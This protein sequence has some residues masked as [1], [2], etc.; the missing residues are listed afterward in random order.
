MEL[1]LNSWRLPWRAGG[2]FD[3]YE[4]L[5]A[6]YVD[7]KTNSR[8]YHYQLN[9]EKKG[10]EDQKMVPTKYA[11]LA[12]GSFWAT[13]NLQPTDAES[14]LPSP[15]LPRSRHTFP[16]EK[17]H[18]FLPPGREKHLS[19]LKGGWITRW[20]CISRPFTK[21]ACILHSLPT[22]FQVPTIYH[23]FKPK[24]SFLC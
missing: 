20:V 3:S 18:Q 14:Y 24:P 22:H 11:I 8:V 7:W 13:G 4:T 16:S 9:T 6:K 1:E 10:E 5:I 2:I 19:S 15:Y 17:I 21:A 12:W 23:P